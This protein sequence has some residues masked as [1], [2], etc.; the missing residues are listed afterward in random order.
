VLGD[1]GERNR[2]EIKGLGRT[3]AGGEN[4]G[5]GSASGELTA[6]EEK[7]R[8]G[9]DERETGFFAGD[10]FVVTDQGRPWERAIADKPRG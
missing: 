5:T 10:L 7:E 9:F 8:K 6:W 1:P 2:G 4:F 3:K